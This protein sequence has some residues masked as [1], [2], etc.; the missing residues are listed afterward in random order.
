MSGVSGAD[1]PGGGSH[2]ESNEGTSMRE[3]TIK[4]VY[5]DVLY[6]AKGA[7]DVRAAVEEA[8]RKG[9]NLGYANLRSADLGSADLR[10]A[11][12]RSANLRSA[13]LR[14]ADLRSAD[15]R[16]ADLRFADLGSANLGSANLGSADLGSAD[17]GSAKGINPNAA[18][19]YFCSASR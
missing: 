14:S 17:L 8:V 6:V 16:F 2:L 7:A 11:N 5:G 19:S 12:L 18:T 13:D 1:A 10:S 3:V 15:L 9:A 4:S